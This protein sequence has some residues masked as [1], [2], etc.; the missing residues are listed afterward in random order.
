MLVE[1]PAD[2]SR[3][4]RIVIVGVTGS[5]KSSLAVRLADAG[6]MPHVRI[7]DLMWRP[8]WVQLDPAAQAESVA[9]HVTGTSW[10]LDGLWTAT[11]EV[12]L[13]RT[14]LVV[15]LDYPRRV[16]LGRLLTRTVR[17]IRAH[18]TTCGGNTETWTRAVSRE[19]IVAWHFRSFHRKHEQIEQLASEP[20]GPPVLRFTDPRATDSWVRNLERLAAAT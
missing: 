9:A 6:G 17:R 19:S 2:L 13:T 15:A 12:V 3:H 5:G 7:D 18:E 4:R 20:D 10:V 11:R 16:S 14:D 1:P 8:G